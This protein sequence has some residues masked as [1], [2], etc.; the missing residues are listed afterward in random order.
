MIMGSIVVKNFRIYLIFYKSERLE[1]FKMKETGI[2]HPIP[3]LCLSVLPAC[4][5]GS[6]ISGGSPP[7]RFF[8]I[9]ILLKSFYHHGSH[10]VILLHLIN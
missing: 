3:S 5:L 10:L 1:S 2:N 7:L 4:L 9:E 8:L 6:V